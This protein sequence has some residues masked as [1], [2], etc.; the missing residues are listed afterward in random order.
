MFMYNIQYETGEVESISAKDMDALQNF[1]EKEKGYHISKIVPEIA[2]FFTQGDLVMFRGVIE[3]T[4]GIINTKLNYTS[5]KLPE[6][7]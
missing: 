7:M 2:P 6:N 3:C 5:Y 1:L 4:K